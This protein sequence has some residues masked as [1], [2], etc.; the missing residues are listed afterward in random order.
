MIPD[1][2]DKNNFGKISNTTP[3]S[4]AISIERRKKPL[5]NKKIHLITLLAFLLG[6]LAP[7]CGFAWGGKY[8]VVD[9]CTTAGIETKIIADSSDEQN[10]PSTVKDDCQFCSN[11]QNIDKI[12]G[13]TNGYNNGFKLATVYTALLLDVLEYNQPQY[14]QSRA[15]PT[16]I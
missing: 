1:R 4:L 2:Y 12:A 16:L 13:Y 8:N 7:A 10:T 6:L 3:L 11:A 5:M 15:P 14:Y 9:I